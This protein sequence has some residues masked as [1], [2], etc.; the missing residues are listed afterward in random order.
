MKKLIIL[1]VLGLVIL[2]IIKRQSLFGSGVIG[3][4]NTRKS[5]HYNLTGYILNSDDK[6]IS[7]HKDC[8]LCHIPKVSKSRENLNP[9]LWNL[10]LSSS[11]FTI[12]PET[13]FLVKP[14][15]NC[16]TDPDGISKLCLS[17]HDGITAKN[18]LA[19]V[20]G[21]DLSN[22]HPISVDYK[23]CYNNGFGNLRA[24]S[25]VYYTS[26]SGINGDSD[27]NLSKTVADRLDVAGKVQCTSCHCLHGNS[28][29]YLLCV[30]NIGSKL[31]LVC[32]NK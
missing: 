20:S 27:T 1:G 17:C 28:E 14:E 10:Q 7:G 9:A 11:S 19:T 2:L 6:T 12:Y 18:I 29:S 13:N 3:S 22:H 26:Y 5:A 32:H 31:C 15:T 21:T 8:A 23:C 25:W 16:K 30:N 4:E 24:T